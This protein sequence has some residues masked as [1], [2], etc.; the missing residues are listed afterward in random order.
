MLSRRFADQSVDFD[1]MQGVVD[2]NWSKQGMM[3]GISGL[4]G[5]VTEKIGD[6]I[7]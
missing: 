5:H 3:G 6:H 7:P 2:K 1:N 4:L